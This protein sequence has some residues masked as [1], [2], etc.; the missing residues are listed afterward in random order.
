MRIAVRQ[1]RREE[2]V[3]IWRE[4][5]A[6]PSEW[7]DYLERLALARNLFALGKR[8]EL[9]KVCVDI[10]YPRL[11]RPAYPVMRM[12]CRRW[13]AMPDEPPQPD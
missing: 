4:L 8:A 9:K 6:D 1:P 12:Q 7:G 10:V 11:W 3:E 5:V 2:A 13:N